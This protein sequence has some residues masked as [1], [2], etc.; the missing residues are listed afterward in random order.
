MGTKTPA[1]HLINDVWK[2]GSFY[3]ENALEEIE[4][5]YGENSAADFVVADSGERRYSIHKK[6]DA[7]D[8]VD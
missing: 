4:F 5:Q 2:R 8:K 1:S 7:S 6:T 3:R